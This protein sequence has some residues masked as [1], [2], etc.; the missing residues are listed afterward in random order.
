M[1]DLKKLQFCGDVQ[2]IIANN[3]KWAADTIKA[4]TDGV[5]EAIKRSNSEK[6][7]MA[8]SLMWLYLDKTGRYSMTDED[9]QNAVKHLSKYFKVEHT[10]K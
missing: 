1:I 2:Q 10:P 8:T 5:D 3:P 4:I 9:K 6:A 7:E